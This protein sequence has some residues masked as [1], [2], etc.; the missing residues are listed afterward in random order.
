MTDESQSRAT[1]AA[2]EAPT[3][4]TPSVAQVT[5][6][7]VGQTK[8][9]MVERFLGVMVVA[10]RSASTPLS[11]SI[12]RWGPSVGTSRSEGSAAL[13]IGGE[14][15]LA[16]TSIGNNSPARGEPLLWWTNPQDLVSTLFALDVVISSS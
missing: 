1:A 15:S 4:P 7:G 6:P 3:R 16:L 11:R 5:V 8:G 12:A 13:G 10:E 2:P 9:D 14:S